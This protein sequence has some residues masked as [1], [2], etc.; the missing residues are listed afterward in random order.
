MEQFE[1]WRTQKLAAPRDTNPLLADDCQ[2]FF[3]K[4]M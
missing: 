2:G 4:L 3:F 1:G